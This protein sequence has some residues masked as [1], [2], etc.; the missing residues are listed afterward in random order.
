MLAMKGGIPVVLNGVVGSTRQKAGNGCPP[1]ATFLVYLHRKI[2]SIRQLEVL[3]L[4]DNVFSGVQIMT[5]DRALYCAQGPRTGVESTGH[6]RTA[7][8]RASSRSEKGAFFTSG[9]S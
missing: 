1:V 8:I 2:S 7:I 6:V 5:H 3:L 9:L 4:S